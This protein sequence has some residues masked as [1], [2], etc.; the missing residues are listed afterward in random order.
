MPFLSTL[1]GSLQTIIL[2]VA[3]LFPVVNPLSG[4]T[5][6]LSTTDGYGPAAKAVLARK[7]ALY[8]FVLLVASLLA[9]SHLLR[10]FGIS[11]AAVQVGGG[12]VVAATGW[13]L[14]NR[15]DRTPEPG[16]RA[17]ASTHD[18]LKHA[19]YPLTLPLSV[20]PGSISVTITLGANLPQHNSAGWLVGWDSIAAA[21]VG[22]AI[23]SFL[24]WLCYYSAQWMSRVLGETG[25]SVVVR[26]SSFIL[27]CIGVQILWN[28]ASTLL[29]TLG[30]TAH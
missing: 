4:A 2:V 23:I 12:L 29:E 19:F 27:L 5:I 1:E 6:F 30:H 17:K 11:L 3:T 21:I 10:F 20:G 14:L 24:V 13:T 8:G 18:L 25:T 9:G 16:A 22:L 15:P 7:V 28:G 26:L